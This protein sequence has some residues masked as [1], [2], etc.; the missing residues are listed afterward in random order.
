MANLSFEEKK[1][2]SRA[3][4]KAWV[5]EADFRSSTYYCYV[6]TSELL[7]KKITAESTVFSSAVF[8]QNDPLPET[9]KPCQYDCSI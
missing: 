2:Q 5:G 3:W 4:T 9:S 8:V 1:R 6:L 7:D